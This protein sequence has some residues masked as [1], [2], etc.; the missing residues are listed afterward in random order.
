[1]EVAFNGALV[2]FS[3]SAHVA[4][5]SVEAVHCISGKSQPRT[6]SARRLASAKRTFNSSALRFSTKWK[7]DPS[8]TDSFINAKSTQTVTALFDEEADGRGARSPRSDFASSQYNENESGEQSADRLR[9]LTLLC[10]SHI[11]KAFGKGSVLRLG[12]ATRMQMNWKL[13]AERSSAEEKRVVDV[14]LDKMHD[15]RRETQTLVDQGRST[16]GGNTVLYSI[17]AFPLLLDIIASTSFLDAG[18]MSGYKPSYDIQLVLVFF[19][20]TG[21]FFFIRASVKDRTEQTTFASLDKPEVLARALNTYFQSR[22]YRLIDSKNDVLTYQGT[23]APSVFLATLLS[24]MALGGSLSVAL[25][26]SFVYPNIGSG[27]YFLSLL[28]PSAGF[29]YWER[30]KRPEEFKLRLVPPPKTGPGAD[31]VSRV[32]VKG[33]REEIEELRV[34]LGFE[35]E[36]PD[37][38]DLFCRGC[39]G[40]GLQACER[41]SGS[42]YV[43]QGMF[44][45]CPE[46]GGAKLQYC[47]KCGEGETARESKELD[48]VKAV[49]GIRQ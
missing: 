10:V 26:L 6:T 24:L 36:D 40:T 44:R 31:F 27:F 4:S 16:K 41:C 48:K 49:A 12:D 20:A 18:G 35:K 23:V 13:A 39:R 8:R 46:C 7:W 29:F 11:E 28:S 25:V 32:L 15:D 2:A 38:E 47:K 33:Q 9:A 43:L 42:G 34:A 19:M 3:L 30:A 1:M 22:A 14:T 45:R 37:R 21:L 17:A 5:L